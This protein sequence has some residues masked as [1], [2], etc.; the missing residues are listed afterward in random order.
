LISERSVFRNIDSF[1]L[2]TF[3]NLITYESLLTARNI[4]ILFGS[5]R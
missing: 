5:L 3:A 4:L 2:C 1:A